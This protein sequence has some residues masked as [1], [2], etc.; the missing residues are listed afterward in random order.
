MIPYDGA[1][2]EQLRNPLVREL[3]AVHDMFRSQLTAMLEYID[4][5][6]DGEL[7]LTAPEAAAR[8]HALIRAGTQYTRML[9]MHHQIETS[10]MFPSLQREGLEV[11]VVDRLNAEHDEIGVLID[12]F[13]VAI[14]DLSAVAPEILDTDLRRLADA[15]QAHLAYEETHVCPLLARFS[16]W[17]L[18]GH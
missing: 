13:S 14:Q 4:E 18:Q 7:P 16:E 6:T 5:L 12:R 11:A 15:L 8:T 1:T 2:V 9:H 3:L 17:P 10:A